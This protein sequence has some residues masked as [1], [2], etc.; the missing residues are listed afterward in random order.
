[1]NVI[2]AVWIVWSLVTLLAVDREL[3]MRPQWVKN[4]WY[5]LTFIVV[6]QNWTW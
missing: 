1:M 6:A 3:S 2:S 4:V 5:V